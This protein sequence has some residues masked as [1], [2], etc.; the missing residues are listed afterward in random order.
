MCRCLPQHELDLLNRK[1]D[2]LMK[3][4]AGTRLHRPRP[5]PTL[6]YDACPAGMAELDEDAG[7]LEA[8]IVN[9]KKEINSKVRNAFPLC[10]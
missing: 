1:F 9:M 7:P 8:T 4:R 10:L 2:Q 6:R 5:P 3:Q